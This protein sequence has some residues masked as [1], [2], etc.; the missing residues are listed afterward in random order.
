MIDLVKSHP[1]EITLLTL[2]PL[3]NVFRAAELYPAFLSELKS[4]VVAGR[5]TPGGGNVTPS[6]EFNVLADPEAARFVLRQPCTKTWSRL[7]S[8]AKLC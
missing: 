5:F 1:N 3:T 4:L 7:M 8:L 6:A 2:G